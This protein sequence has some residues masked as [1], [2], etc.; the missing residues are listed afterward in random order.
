MSAVWTCPRIPPSVQDVP[1][2][3]QISEPAGRN[4][5][6]HQSELVIGGSARDEAEGLGGLSAYVESWRQNYIATEV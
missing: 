3:L 4:S 5:G 1:D 2:L 6:R